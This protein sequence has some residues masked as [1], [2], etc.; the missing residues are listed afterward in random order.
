MTK[1]TISSH[2]DSKRKLRSRQ[3]HLGLVA[4][5]LAGNQT[6]VTLEGF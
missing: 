2:L 3:G 5:V 1:Q 6:M 4:L